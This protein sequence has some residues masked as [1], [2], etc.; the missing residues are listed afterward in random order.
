MYK[1][2]CVINIESNRN[3]HSKAEETDP[4]QCRPGCAACCIVISISSPLPGMPNGKPAG[5]RCVNLDALNRCKI[6]DSPDYPLVCQKHK[7]TLEFCGENNEEAIERL[8]ELERLTQIND[9][10]PEPSSVFESDSKVL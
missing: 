4:F 3:L 8:S 9:F 1:V 6:H 7:A 5:V 2:N 10:L